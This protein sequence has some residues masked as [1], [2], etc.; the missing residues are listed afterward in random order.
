M[1]RRLARI[2]YSLATILCSVSMIVPASVHAA[3]PNSATTGQALEIA[4]P[5]LTLSA[6]PGQTIHAQLSLRDVSSGSLFVTGQ[7]NDF[8]AAGEDGTPKI[9]LDNETNNPY[10]LKDWIAP[11][12]SLTLVSREIKT[13]PVT[14]NIPANAAPGGHY[15]VIRFT[16]TAPE[17]HDTGVS[18][19]ASLGSLVLVTVNGKIKES[20]A[21]QEFSANKNGKTGTLF[22]SA[23]LNFVARI[24]NNGNVHEQPVGQVIITDMFGKKLAAVNV[25]VP[26]HNIL[27]ASIRKFSQ[28]LDGTVIGNKKLFGHYTAKLKLTYGTN[29]QTLT[30]SLGFW[31]IPYRLIAFI[32]LLLVGGF[33]LIRTAIKRYNRL[34]ITK[35][36]GTKKKKK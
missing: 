5:V 12:Q 26:P 17:L 33:F 36:Q 25:N 20:L 21:V 31:V 3:T 10:S 14:I 23:P 19:S 22:E 35:A 28:P 15:G 2:G 6:N 27:P 24:K 8:L 13:L 1:K 9:I 18:L 32:I 16:A 4:P 29:K 34:I 30:A 11:L 7:V